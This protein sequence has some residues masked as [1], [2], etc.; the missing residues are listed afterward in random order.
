MRDNRVTQKLFF[1]LEE[2]PY[3]ETIN[4]YLKDVHPEELQETIC[5]LVKGLI[6]RDY[7]QVVVDGTQLYSSREKLDGKCL[8][9]VHNRGTEKEYTEY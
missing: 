2:V 9:R 1:L 8:Y 7:W 5:K 4:N 6:R 3:W